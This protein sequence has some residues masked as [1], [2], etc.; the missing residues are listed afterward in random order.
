MSGHCSGHWKFGELSGHWKFS[1]L[2][3]HFSGHWKFSELSDHFSGHWK[4][5]ELSGHFS[6]RW[7]FSKLSGP[8]CGRS[9]PKSEMRFVHECCSPEKPMLVGYGPL[10]ATLC[11]IRLSTGRPATSIS[12]WKILHLTITFENTWKFSELF[13]SLE[14]Q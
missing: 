8:T 13:W 11:H 4:F 5:S 14:V 7:K 6:G 3:G 12:Q 1:E 2:S 9:A 10:N